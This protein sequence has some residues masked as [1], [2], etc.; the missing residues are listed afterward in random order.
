MTDCI[1]ARDVAGMFVV[2]HH[3]QENRRR[4]GVY[5]FEEA[6]HLYVMGTHVNDPQKE[7]DTFEGLLN[8][9]SLLTPFPLEIVASAVY[10]PDPN[11]TDGSW[12]VLTDAPPELEAFL[13]SVSELNRQNHGYPP[14]Q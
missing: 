9:M 1:R 2:H 8:V 12:V 6:G 3:E 13:M 11:V 14:M 10:R 4:R 5:E 7:A